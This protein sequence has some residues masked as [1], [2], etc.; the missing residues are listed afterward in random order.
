[1]LPEK[2]NMPI[3]Y[4]YLYLLHAA[5]SPNFSEF[6]SMYTKAENSCIAPCKQ[7]DNHAQHAQHATVTD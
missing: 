3:L 4:L 2:G 6:W 7:H 1:M 5:Q